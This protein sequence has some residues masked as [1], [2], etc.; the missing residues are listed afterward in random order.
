MVS[1]SMRRAFQVQA[2]TVDSSSTVNRVKVERT[3]EG[4]S[5]RGRDTKQLGACT[6]HGVHCASR[7][8]RQNNS[9]AR[10]DLPPRAR[11]AVT[12]RNM[13]GTLTPQHV[14]K[15]VGRV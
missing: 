10:E 15:G 7:A 13:L 4:C 14:I 6:P 2:R 8:Q 5:C 9:R 11:Q 1:V 12:Q 3:H